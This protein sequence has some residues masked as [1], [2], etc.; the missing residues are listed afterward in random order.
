MSGGG[1][2]LVTRPE[3]EAGDTVSRL[4]AMGREAIA[5]PMLR[6]EKVPATLPGPGEVQ[7]V[8]LGSINA[9]RHLPLRFRRVP[10]LAVGDAT[11][12]A[13]R[14]RGFAKVT[15]AGGDARDLAALA[16]RV[17]DPAGLPLL[18]ATARGAGGPLAAD[19][20]GR[21]FRVHRRVTYRAVALPRLGEAADA[22]RD[23]RVGEA[24]FFSSSAARVFAR[25]A[26][27]MRL[28]HTLGG[29]TALAISPAVAATLGR[30]GF[31][32]VLTASRPDQESM[33][34]LFGRKAGAAGTRK[35]GR[36]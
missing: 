23:G 10:V 2:V 18:L 20:R 31:R 28:T 7:A 9:V 4:A 12:E 33:L 3:P 15:S 27:A 21:G 6:I 36:R 26:R 35:G 5:A 1:L 29:I 22:L 34:A 19:L 14:A 32:A 24:L 13:A 25:V 11:A 8:V 30:S 17:C 16:T